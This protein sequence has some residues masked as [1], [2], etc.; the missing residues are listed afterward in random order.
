MEP[1]V[2]AHA[3][4]RLGGRRVPVTYVQPALGEDGARSDRLL[5]IA[6]LPEG[7]TAVETDAVRAF[8]REYY[9]ALGVDDLDGDADLARMERELRAPGAASIELASLTDV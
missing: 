5:L 9:S 7:T 2:R 4:A 3:M 8:L 6:F 1:A